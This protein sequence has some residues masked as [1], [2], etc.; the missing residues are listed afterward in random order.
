MR[1]TIVILLAVAFAAGATAAPAAAPAPQ[2][3]TS[4]GVGQVKL[5]K[6]FATLRAQ[7]LVGKL[8]KGCELA[9]NTRSARLRSPL[10]GS[11]NF[12]QSNPRK[13][14]DI[15]IRGGAEARGVGIGDTIADIKAAFK[16]RRID[17]TQEPVFGLTF[18]FV[19]NKNNPRLMF[20]VDVNTKKIT[21]IGTPII[22]LCE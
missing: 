15:T 21:L 13:A 14:T 5:G 3:I 9:A 17:H 10:S 19:P 22:A 16:K 7:G 2:K 12:T 11:V 4:E 1:R 18:V 6:T 8:R 20:A